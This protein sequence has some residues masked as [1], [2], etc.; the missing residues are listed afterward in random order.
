MVR[1]LNLHAFASLRRVS[2]LNRPGKRDR[3]RPAR[4]RCRLTAPDSW[5][6]GRRSDRYGLPHRCQA[7]WIAG[8]LSCIDGRPGLPGSRPM[9]KCSRRSDEKRPSLKL[10]SSGTWRSGMAR[11][12]ATSVC[13][14]FRSLT[15]WLRHTASSA[16]SSR[17]S[18]LQRRHPAALHAPDR[19]VVRAR[20]HLHQRRRR[21]AH[22]KSWKPAPR[23]D[24][25][26][27]PAESNAQGWCAT[28]GTP[29]TRALRSSPARHPETPHGQALC[30]A[31]TARPPF[32][33]AFRPSVRRGGRSKAIEPAGPS[34]LRQ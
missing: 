8:T 1:T 3:P 2:W 12:S 19:R 31:A 5:A 16:R 4:K 33:K 10:R 25:G 30:G 9:M 6:G 21:A 15:R 7:P 18:G 28:A 14:R 11:I 26:D 13:F 24:L 29:A 20:R 17:P 32:G 34:H 22:K 23:V 27:F